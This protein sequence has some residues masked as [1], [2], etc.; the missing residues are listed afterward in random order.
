MRAELAVLLLQAAR[1]PMSVS[2]VHIVRLA[3]FL[4]ALASFLVGFAGVVGAAVL[5]TLTML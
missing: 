1:R 5:A 4:V 3:D 2:I